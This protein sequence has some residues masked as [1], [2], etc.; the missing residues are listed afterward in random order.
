[1][2]SSKHF[3][4]RWRPLVLI[5]FES[6]R[7]FGRHVPTN[8]KE[9]GVLVLEGEEISTKGLPWVSHPYAGATT[10]P[11]VGWIFPNGET[12]EFTPMFCPME[13]V[14]DQ[15]T[16]I[17]ETRRLRRLGYY[18]VRAICVRAYGEDP[19]PTNIKEPGVFVL[20]Y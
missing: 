20:D 2:G 7:V 15:G 18:D 11:M 9:P 5:P 17:A 6:G 4:R 8:I 16:L 14:F 1:L 3:A 10:H 13:D 19:F 12:K